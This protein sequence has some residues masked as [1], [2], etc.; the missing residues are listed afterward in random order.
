VPD[1]EPP[2]ELRE[3]LRR[4]FD[5]DAE[6]YDRARPGYPSAMVDDLV[7]LAALRP[8]SRVL[9]IGCGTGQ[10]S[11]PLVQRG[12][13]LTAVEL[14][15]ELAALARRRL[16]AVRPGT[17]EVVQSAYE[18]WVPPAEPFDMV[19]AATSFHWIDP[20]VRVPRSVAL[21]RPGGSLAVVSTVHVAGGDDAFTA[22]QDCYL[23]WDPDVDEAT[24]LLAPDEVPT[25][26]P[27]L[28]EAPSLEPV[29]LRRYVWDQ[30]YTS[31]EYVDLLLTYSGHR[32]L[33][34]DLRT[35]LL[36]CIRRTVDARGGQITKTY[37]TEL[38][39]AR[40]HG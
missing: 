23:R 40:R 31:D 29:R 27:E 28:D 6:G 7:A 18:V 37:L 26:S 16:A 3:S 35:G 8:G 17:A 21:L 19:V 32:A 34:D 11:L 9:E 33:R 22:L 5:E 1:G 30:T 12:L 25:A 38:R 14:G 20:A 13:D 2:E 36:D 15:A 24:R 39:V 4:R 10:L